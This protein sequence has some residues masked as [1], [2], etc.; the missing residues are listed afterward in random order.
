MK[1][2]EIVRIAAHLLVS[3]MTNLWTAIWNAIDEVAIF[4]LHVRSSS[5]P[6]AEIM[7]VVIIQ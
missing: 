7:R 1:K 6:M 4:P 5:S 3:G 2:D